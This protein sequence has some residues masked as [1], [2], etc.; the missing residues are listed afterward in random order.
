MTRLVW[1]GHASRRFVVGLLALHVL[2]LGWFC[3][4][5]TR[6]RLVLYAFREVPSEAFMTDPPDALVPL[7][8]SEDPPEQLAAYRRL[9]EP[10]VAGAASDGQKLRRLGDFIYSLRRSEAP[11]VPGAV[12]HPL[13]E[14]LSG[15]QQGRFGDCGHMSILLAAF[16]RSLGGHIR[17]VHWA[18]VE[19][20]LGH[21]AVEAYST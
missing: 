2:A 8:Y 5:W 12:R 19:G 18:T 16:W 3:V 13:S 14:I 9:A 6:L 15:L 21:E 10:V 20:D 17:A 1:G 11:E 4:P 7:G